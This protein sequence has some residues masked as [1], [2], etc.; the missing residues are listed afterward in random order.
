[1]PT[2]WCNRVGTAM[3]HRLDM[4]QKGFESRKTS[5]Q[6]NC[7]AASCRATLV[8][9]GNTEQFA[10]RNRLKDAGRGPAHVDAG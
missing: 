5:R 4:G 8:E 1:M 10:T 3:H 2:R 6:P 9:V 7:S